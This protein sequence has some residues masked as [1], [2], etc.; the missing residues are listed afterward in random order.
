MNEMKSTPNKRNLF[1]VI[2][3][4]ASIGVAIVA[5]NYGNQDPSTGQDRELTIGYFSRAIGYAPYFVA[6]EKGW[7]EEHPALDGKDVKHVIYG[8]RA[9]I[10]D[11]FDSGKLDVLLSA[12]IPAIMCRAQ[13]ND[14][15]IIDVTGLITLH[16]LARSEL[17]ATGMPDFSGKAVAYQSGTSSHYG[18]LTTL[19]RAGLDSSDFTLR[20][21]KA[22]EAQTAFEAGQVDAWI[23]WSPFFEQQVINGKGSVVPNSKYNYA[24]TLTASQSLIEKEPEVAQALTEILDRAQEWIVNNPSEA[25]EIVAT[26]TRQELSV[27]KEALKNVS[28]SASLDDEML[29]M[30]QEMAEFLADNEI[31]RQGKT[32]NIREEMYRQLRVPVG[33]GN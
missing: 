7:F 15:R 19:D 20:N 14:I 31:V 21:M 11:S 8:D 13:G 3:A 18:L 30:F 26:A 9:T 28:F 27:A 1:L 24:T 2:A 23:V 16:W 17:D 5:I 4:L 33:A 22:V 12:E 29:N 10:A 25:E 6:Q 32:V